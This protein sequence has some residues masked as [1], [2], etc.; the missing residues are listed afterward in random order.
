MNR[1]AC[2]QGVA[3]KRSLEEHAPSASGPEAKKMAASQ[4]VVPGVQP[5]LPLNSVSEEWSVP[6]KMVGLIIGALAFSLSFCTL[7]LSFV[8]RLLCRPDHDDDLLPWNPSLS[9]VA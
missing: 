8:P 7:L 1:F 9:R 2:L 5:P 6:D 4:T 3:L